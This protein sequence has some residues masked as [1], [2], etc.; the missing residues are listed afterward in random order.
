MVDELAGQEIQSSQVLIAQVQSTYSELLSAPVVL[1]KGDVEVHVDRQ[2]IFVFLTA[3]RE[4]PALLFNLFV[5]VTAVDWMDARDDRFEVVYHLRSLTHGHFIRVRVVVPEESPEIDSSVNLW[6]GANFM[7]REVWDMY[8]IVFKGHPD[9]TGILMYEEFKGYPLRKDYPV[10]GKQPRIPMRSPEVQNTA[11]F[12]ERP[13][14]VQIGS[15]R[16]SV[17]TSKKS[18]NQ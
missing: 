7:E 14:L 11:V 17:E 4:D 2:H 16:Q 6:A 13:T 3:M 9:L 18:S 10:Q 1:N 15:R 12:M 5:S 8:G